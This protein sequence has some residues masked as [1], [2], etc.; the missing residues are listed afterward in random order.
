MN[1]W[2]HIRL[3]GALVIIVAACISR[4]DMVFL[5]LLIQFVGVIGGLN[6]T[7]EQIESLLSKFE[8]EDDNAVR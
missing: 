4:Q 7:E 8:K 6:R 1:I 3:A 2:R 5:G